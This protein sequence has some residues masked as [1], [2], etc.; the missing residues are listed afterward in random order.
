MNKY[1]LWKYRIGI[2]ILLFPLFFIN[3][4]DTHDWGDD[5]AQYLIQTRNIVEG[6]PQTDNGLLHDE[7]D[8]EY[9]I[10]AYPVGLPL[11]LAPIYFFSG[12]KILPYCIFYS[13]ILF[14]TGLFIFEYF[15]GRSNALTALLIALLFC[16]NVN[17][18][19]LK[20]QILSE[21]PF[22]CFLFLTLLSIEKRNDLKNYSW[23]ITGLLFTILVSVR[24]AGISIICGYII[25]EIAKLLSLSVE[26]RKKNL[27]NVILTLTVYILTFFLINGIIFPIRVG[28]L[29]N[30]Y[31]TALT[32][33]DLQ[34][35]NNIL[36]YYTVSEYI[37]PF[38]GKSIPSFWIIIVLGGWLIKTFRSA[39]LLEFIFPMYCLLILFY[40][41]ADAGI[42]FM[43]PVL[44]I[45]VYYA[46]YFINAMFVKL[47]TRATWAGTIA[48]LV[49][50][51][52]YV[53]PLK[54][55]IQWQSAEEDGPQQEVSKQLFSY[56]KTT[57]EDASMVFCK[58]RAM[59]LYSERHS[60]Y[61]AK[62]QS[63]DEAYELFH[64]YRNLY[65][66]IA[67]VKPDNEI[68]DPRLLNYISKYKESY[69]HVW[70]N[71]HFD[72]YK[73]L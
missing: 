52:S 21:L 26:A 36:F 35:K 45:L 12:L 40:P 9:A 72:V 67:K 66:V 58:A 19:D 54:G 14:L 16:Y 49:L 71:E 55:I 33:H 70:S 44:A 38:F 46:G 15:R 57:P 43:L 20:K 53:S 48:L 51:S 61:P 8:P 42:R 65:L 34:L 4:K 22:T 24:L 62:R 59:S 13:L 28:G 73:Q 5:F 11:M 25:F 17:I 23:L 37:F 10:Q 47:K 18:L 56:L 60:I 2:A 41:Y 1:S 64:R 27:K 69:D 68:Y 3:I 32:T 29:L 63:V 7:K 6:K 39:T 50:T 31:T 30:F